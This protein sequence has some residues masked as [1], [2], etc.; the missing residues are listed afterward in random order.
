M[1]QL[2]GVTVD[3]ARLA[4]VCARYGVARLLVFGSV[5]RGTATPDSDIDVLY[6]L[7]PGRRL[8]WEI[9][10]LADELAALFGRPVDL[11]SPAALHRR[12]KDTVLSEARTL[13]AA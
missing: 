11:V 3:E 4:E 2:P 10:Q 9:E 12:L 13:Y 5:A 6:E 1:P 8:G 7:E